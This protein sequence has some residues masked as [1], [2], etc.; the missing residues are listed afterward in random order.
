MDFHFY[1]EIHRTQIF[2]RKITAN[3]KVSH[4]LPT[5]RSIKRSISNILLAYLPD[6]CLYGQRN[7]NSSLN[8]LSSMVKPRLKTTL[9]NNYFNSC[10]YFELDMLVIEAKNF[11]SYCLKYNLSRP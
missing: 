7:E 3:R 5:S 2:L 4:S 6:R 10:T 1:K 9:K 11:N 8:A